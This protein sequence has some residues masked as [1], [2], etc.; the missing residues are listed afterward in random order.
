MNWSSI[1]EGN[2][3]GYIFT[4]IEEGRDATSQ[5]PS[6]HDNNT[7]V[8]GLAS[9]VKTIS[10]LKLYIF[11]KSQINIFRWYLFIWVLWENIGDIIKEKRMFYLSLNGPMIIILML[12]VTPANTCL[13]RRPFCLFDLIGV[14]KV[15][16]CVCFERPCGPLFTQMGPKGVLL[17]TW[18]SRLKKHTTHS[19]CYYYFSYSYY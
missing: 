2:H 9:R 16:L 13:V 14:Q 1:P 8:I 17:L 7:L 5:A 3:W 11:I 10:Y 4:P 12:V 15:P 19:L 6:I 18:R